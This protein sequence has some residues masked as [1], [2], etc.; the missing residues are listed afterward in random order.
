MSEHAATEPRV[1]YE[2]ILTPKCVFF[3]IKYTNKHK[4][5]IILYNAHECDQTHTANR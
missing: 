3:N 4:I 1:I 2:R 5:I